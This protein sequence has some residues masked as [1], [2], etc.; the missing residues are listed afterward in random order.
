MPSL[1]TVTDKQEREGGPLIRALSELPASRQAFL[2]ASF[3]ESEQFSPTQ[4]I[5]RAIERA[6]LQEPGPRG[7]F[8]SQRRQDVPMLTREVANER[9]KDFGLKYDDDVP[10]AL[11]EWDLRNKRK[12]IERRAILERSRGPLTSALGIGAQF[13]AQAKDPINIASAF[14]PVVGPTRFAAMVARIGVTRARAVTGLVEGAVGASLVEP[15]VLAQARAEQSDYGP[16]DAL[17]NVTFGTLLGGGLHVGAG[18]VADVGARLRGRPT[19]GQRVSALP[20]QSRERLMRTAVASLAEGRQVDIATLL[21]LEEADL[22]VRQAAVRG[23]TVG[24]GTT[25]RREAFDLGPLEEGEFRQVSRL[26]DAERRELDEVLTAVRRTD[27]TEQREAIRAIEERLAAA[28]QTTPRGPDRR[29]RAPRRKVEPQEVEQAGRKL[30]RGEPIRAE[31]A[32]VAQALADEVVERRAARST[33]AESPDLAARAREEVRAEATRRPGD[34]SL[35]SDRGAAAEIELQV[36]SQRAGQ[37]LVESAQEELDEAMERLNAVR[38]A[39]GLGAEETA[40]TFAEFDEAIEQADA[41][42]RAVRA[43]AL[44]QLRR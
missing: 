7:R 25:A 27:T 18:A 9:G 33:A 23:E 31:E 26:T 38:E 19:L 16:A 21:D 5:G 3:E 11:F 1:L 22:A 14:I 8:P 32:P 36:S 44:C 17:L 43:A 12:E 4:S 10:E 2:E 28:E 40:E 37:D 15:I 30:Q 20:L 29:R 41:I 39:T 34:D 42:A 13:L 6:D 24:T 35:S